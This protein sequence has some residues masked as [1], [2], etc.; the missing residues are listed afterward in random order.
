MS[1]QVLLE[2]WGGGEKKV[3]EVI[4]DPLSPGRHNSSMNLL[5]GLHMTHPAH[6][7]WQVFYKYF[8]NI[9]YLSWIKEETMRRE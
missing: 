7:T 1:H 8:I 4:T 2:S 6:C 3:G 9:N 5:Y